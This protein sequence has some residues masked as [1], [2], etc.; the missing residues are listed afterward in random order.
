MRI[1]RITIDNFRGIKTTVLYPTNH[2]VFIGDNNVGKTTLLKTMDLALGPDRLNPL[3]RYLCDQPMR[4]FFN[5][6]PFCAT[7]RRCK[8]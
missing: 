8:K 7:I 5:K 3:K 1:S 4:V 6:T 2:A